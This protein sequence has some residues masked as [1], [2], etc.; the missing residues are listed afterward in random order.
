MPSSGSPG[1]LGGLVA[2]AIAAIAIVVFIV[3]ATLIIILYL[4]KI[5]EIA[6]FSKTRYLINI[7]FG[8]I[9]LRKSLN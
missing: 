6:I 3:I 7:L 2:G 8:R 5:S 1:D 9:L 4:I